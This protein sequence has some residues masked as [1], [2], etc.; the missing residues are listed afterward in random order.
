VTAGVAS[1]RGKTALVTGGAH[2]IGR[3][4]VETLAASGCNVVIHYSR[5]EDDARNLARTLSLDASSTAPHIHTVQADLSDPAAAEALISNATT[6]CGASIDF[7][8]NNASA[9]PEQTWTDTTYDQ[10]DAMMRLHAWAPL[11]IMRAAASQGATAAV[12]LL[13]TRMVSSDARHA[14]YMLSKQALWHLTRDMARTLAPMRVNGIAPGPI[15][16]PTGGSD[17]DLESA[18]KATILQQVGSP[19]GI[20][21]AARFLLENEFVTGDVIFVDGGRHLNG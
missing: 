6:S 15:L 20:A 7:V 21:H 12:N 4:I 2:R 11:A 16:P 19:E 1:L 5:S 8:I 3:E 9:F 10:L 18:R 13:D 17:A 14:P